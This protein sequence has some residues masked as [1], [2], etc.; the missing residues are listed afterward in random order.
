MNKIEITDEIKIIFDTLNNAGYECFMVGGCVRDFLLNIVPNDVDFTTNATPN[1]MKECFKDFNVIETGIKHGT[2]TVL[3]NHTPYEITTYRID[4]EYLD[5]RRP[6]NVTFVKDIKNDLARRD[7]TINAIAYNPSVGFVDCFNGMQ[8]LKDGIIR[9]VREPLQRLN[10]DSL[11]ILRAL[12]FSAVLGYEIEPATEKACFEL[13]HL[14]KNISAERIV[15]ELFKTIVQP[16]AHKIMFDY[17]DIWGIVIPELLKIKGFEQ[18]NPHHVHDVLKHTCVALQGADKDLIVRLTILFHDIGKPDSFTM[19]EKGNGHFYGHAIKSVNITRDILD[20]LKVDNNTKNQVLT[21]I[22]YHDLDLQ[23]TERYVKRLC[24]KLGDLEMVKNLILVQRA[25]NFGQAPIH[26][27]RIEKFNQIDKIIK[28]LEQQ[29][30][31]FSLK[32]LAVNGNDL[33]NL[34]LSGKEI[35]TNLKYLLEAVLND[36]VKNE[37]EKLLDYLSKNK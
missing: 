31:S 29:N 23:P 32:D 17:I 28:K 24:Y 15:V 27:E 10:E 1:E 13:S 14:L 4:G 35:G 16:N 25:D 6:E 18:H 11:R 33:I 36:D 34:G 30:L 26:S 19:D 12:R 5:N 37:K 2:L 3:I 8:D 21:L 9:C 20:R 22:K 7:F